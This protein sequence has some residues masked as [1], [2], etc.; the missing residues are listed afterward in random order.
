MTVREILTE[1]SEILHE[2]AAPVTY[3]DDDLRELV[4]DLFETM[5]AAEG[6]GLAAPQVGV[7]QRVF[8]MDASWKRGDKQPL[9]VLNPEIKSREWPMVVEDETCLSIP[10]KVF[11]VP[12]PMVVELSWTSINGVPITQKL[13]GA[14]SR[15]VCHEVDHL[16]G[17]LASARGHEA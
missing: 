13:W 8:V 14:E 11:R 6:R 1:E 7:S 9:A 15:I 10:G 2:K 16:D 5:Y 17:I 3:F 12:R 4:T